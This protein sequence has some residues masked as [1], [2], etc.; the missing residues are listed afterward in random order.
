M[1]DAQATATRH[2]R[3]EHGDEGFVAGW[4]QLER[5][6]G[7]QAPILALRI[8]GIGWG[9][10]THIGRHRRLPNRSRVAIPRRGDSEILADT[11]RE[12]CAGRHVFCSQK[13]ALGLPLQIDVKGGVA[14]WTLLPS[15][16]MVQGLAGLRD[17]P[18][19][20][21]RARACRV[22][23]ASFV[24]GTVQQRQNFIFARRHGLIIDQRCGARDSQLRLEVL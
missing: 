3:P 16:E 19:E 4:A 24:E 9:T 13:L 10:Q 21:F 20:R 14:V 17:E 5:I 8:E 18:I 7:D 15:R 11:D 12:A 23:A 2:L 6:G 22:G 1:V